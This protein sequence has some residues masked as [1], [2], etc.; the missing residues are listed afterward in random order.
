M[1]RTCPGTAT[2][3]SSRS[4][5]QASPAA[6]SVRSTPSSSLPFRRRRVSRLPCRHRTVG[7]RALPR[8]TLRPPTMGSRTATEVRRTARLRVRLGSPPVV[9]PRTHP[10]R[11]SRG[12]PAAPPGSPL[13]GPRTTPT[14][15][16]LPRAAPAGLSTKSGTVGTR[17]RRRLERASRRRAGPRLDR[18]SPRQPCPGPRAAPPPRRPRRRPHRDRH[19]PARTPNLPP[20]ARRP[21]PT[22]SSHRRATGATATATADPTTPA[23]ATATA[24]PTTPAT[25]HRRTGA[26]PGAADTAQFSAV[27]K[28]AATGPATAPPP[29]PPSTSTENAKSPW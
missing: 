24:H 20:A 11:R 23:T 8:T 3:P 6:G 1:G 19:A 14:V 26:N 22:N 15:R 21:S 29:P 12:S 17:H 5:A 13:A 27:R 9:S 7:P 10:P 18:P 28:S 2:S 25:A 4:P 16:S